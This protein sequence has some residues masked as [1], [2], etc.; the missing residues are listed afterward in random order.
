MTLYESARLVSQCT[1][2][3][4][5]LMFFYF[6]FSTAQYLICHGRN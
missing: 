4:V 1:A 3:G 2:A 6:V 5:I